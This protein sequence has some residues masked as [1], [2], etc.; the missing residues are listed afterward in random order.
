MRTAQLEEIRLRENVRGKDTLGAL[1]H[2]PGEMP[3]LSTLSEGDR[4]RDPSGQWADRVD[5]RDPAP[6]SARVLDSLGIVVYNGG[7]WNHPFGG[8][9]IDR[10]SPLD[11]E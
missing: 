7:Q 6:L 8:S 4:H 9:S 1:A 11:D 5:T 3:G 10:G 2:A